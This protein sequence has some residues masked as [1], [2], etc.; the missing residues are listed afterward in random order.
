M[1]KIDSLEELKQIELGILKQVDS[2]CRKENIRY[3]LCGGTL[4][5]AVR[6][7][8]FIPWDDDIDIFMPRPDYEKFVDFCTINE[9]PFRL[10]SS[11][12]DF[13]YGYLFAK[14]MDKRTTVQ[15]LNG[16][17]GGV[18]LGVWI[19]IFP[20]DGLGETFEQAKKNFEKTSF[21]R[22][23]LVA[24]NWKRFFKSKTRSWIYEPIRLAF[25]L[26]SRFVDRQK[27]IKKIQSRYAVKDFDSSKFAGVVCGSYRLKEILPIDV[28]LEY[29][30][31]VFEGNE[32]M[33][34]KD[35]EVYLKNIYGD[36]MQ[37]P[38]EEKRVA[39]H[40]FDAYYK[41]L[42]TESEEK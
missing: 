18:E 9:T 42:D 14:A 13:K 36:Y 21:K 15:E 23:L 7:G 4:L 16:N 29:D 8:G 32:F 17:R 33:V 2:I 25:F 24:S 22:E 30:T 12:T 38:P 34:I 11:Q 6:H 19:D 35:K 27:T 28:Y 20:V 40:T 31:V 10:I 3:S 26:L 5:G 39:H 1:V 37:L 41:S